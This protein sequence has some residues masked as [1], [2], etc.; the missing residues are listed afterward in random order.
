MPG[1]VGLDVGTPG[2]KT[3]SITETGEVLGAP[4]AGSERVCLRAQR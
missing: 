3:L 2:V 1:L 4:A